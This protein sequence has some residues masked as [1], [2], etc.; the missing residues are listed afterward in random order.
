MT[1]G[2]KALHFVFLPARKTTP[3]V[4]RFGILSVRAGSHKE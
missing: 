2:K 1:R 3:C 4:W